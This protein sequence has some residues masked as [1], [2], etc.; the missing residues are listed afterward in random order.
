MSLLE[1]VRNY[2]PSPNLDSTDITIVNDSAILANSTPNK[3]ENKVVSGD[4]I[5]VYVVRKGDT[6]SA[7]AKMFD[8]SVNTIFW[9]NDIPRGGGIKVGQKL[10]ILPV[11]GIKYTVKKG[12]TMAKIAA[13]YKS[14]ADEI[15][16]F[17]NIEEQEKLAVGDT[18]I[19]PNA[20]ESEAPS[21]N[22]KKGTKGYVP[23]GNSSF[24][25]TDG[26]FIRPVPGRKTQGIHGHNGIDFHADKGTSVIAAAAGA[27]V[28]S[29]NDGWNGGYGRYI[30]ITHSNGT[31]TLYAHLSGN[32][33][34]EGQEVF[35]GQL[36]GYSG[37]TGKSFGPHLHFEIR[38][39]RNPF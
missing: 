15:R 30:V 31:Q 21:A 32:V 29:R 25:A 11:S 6:L 2:D 37:D 1:A 20:V 3:S 34:S 28:V 14:D 38:G 35:Q 23:P 33:A 8:V 13:L 27:V 22:L 16:S 26:Y 12:D 39:G 24:V 4:Q 9:A 17:N 10:V 7:I 18:I 36:I 5:S 19:I